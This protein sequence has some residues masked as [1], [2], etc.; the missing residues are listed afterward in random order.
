[1]ERTKA[2]S[3]LTVLRGGTIFTGKVKKGVIEDGWVVIEDGKISSIGTGDIKKEI[4]GR[5]ATTID[6]S[7]KIVLPGLINCH[8]H[9]YSTLARGIM[10]AGYAPRNF[11]Q[12]LEGLWWRLDRALTYEDCYWSAL[13]G[14][15]LSL[16]CGVTTILD[17]HSSPFCIDR[18]LDAVAGGMSEAGTRGAT[19][20]EVS[21]RDGQ[22]RASLGIYENVRFAGVSTDVARDL[23][24]PMMG[25][26]ASFTLSQ[27]T[28]LRARDAAAA[29]GIGCHLHV[30]E[31]ALD[32]KDSLKRY[33]RRVVTRLAEAGVLSNK[34]LAVHCVHVVDSEIKQLHETAT[35]VAVCPRS[36]LSNAVGIAPMGKMFRHGV[37]IGF[38][39]DGFGPPGIME[40]ARAGLLS[41]RVSEAN[42][43]A[44]WVETQ[45]MLQRNNPVIAS[46]ILG[47]KVG[48]LVEGQAGDVVV[49]SYDPPTPLV[50][51]NLW[52][53]MI[54]ADLGIDT[55][56]VGGRVVVRDGRSTLLDEGKV[57]EKARG[58]AQAL[59]ERM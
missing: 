25:L 30:A 17:H 59:W 53:H 41:W 31:D 40:D 33:R 4:K 1:L 16:K 49:A 18:S 50:P 13:A 8:T 47:Y 27:P 57:F 28:L 44:A 26:H 45:L 24:A 35:N 6:A 54:F 39:S 36:N 58:L 29:A 7:G 46:T 19:C 34:T 15:L 37:R 56:V 22:D 43:A 55:V 2:Q 9:L 42:P 12:C 23:V 32:V 21:D 14:S 5:K 38:G 3:E 10:L 11:G 48:E 52:G 51:D 20:Y